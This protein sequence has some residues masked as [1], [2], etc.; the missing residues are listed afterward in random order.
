MIRQI[1]LKELYTADTLSRAPTCISNQTSSNSIVL[2]ELS[3]MCMTAAISHLP[4]S[5]K[6]L[7]IYRRPQSEDS[8]CQ[9]I[10]E[11]CRKEWPHKKELDP[12][13]RGYWEAQGELTVGNYGLLMHGYQIVVPKAFQAET[14]KKLYEGH[15]GIVQCLIRAK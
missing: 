4:G 3:E 15:Q 5:D 7:E 2:Q 1:Q 6:R 10:P 9:Q 12:S 11:Y 13:V 14:L 8:I